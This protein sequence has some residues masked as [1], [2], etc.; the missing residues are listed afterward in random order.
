M[1]KLILK[2]VV[3]ANVAIAGA[4]AHATIVV[5]EE[6]MARLEE[7]QIIEAPIGGIKNHFWFDYRNNVGEAQKELASD[8]RG[9]SDSED[10]RDA[11]DE[12]R[13]ELSGERRHYIKEMRERGYRYGTVTVGD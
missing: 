2:I 8:L 6:Q 5:Y 4:T 13:S 11:W 9:V 10:L 3:A 7:Q 12:Y 1:R